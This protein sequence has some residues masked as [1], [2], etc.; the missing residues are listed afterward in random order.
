[1]TR[2]EWSKAYFDLGRKRRLWR[3]P[4][5]LHA[6]AIQHDTW[7]PA[8]PTSAFPAPVDE[9]DPVHYD[10]MIIDSV[11]MSMKDVEY[12]FMWDSR[13]PWK[14]MNSGSKGLFWRNIGWL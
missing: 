1:M 9:Y 5:W 6:H 8:K 14:R 12:A 11:Q 10:Q 7:T 3:G 13:K 4:R 2:Y